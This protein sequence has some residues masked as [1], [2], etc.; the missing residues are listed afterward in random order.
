MKSVDWERSMPINSFDE[1]N[2]MIYVVAGGSDGK[3]M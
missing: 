2:I 1:M 3:T